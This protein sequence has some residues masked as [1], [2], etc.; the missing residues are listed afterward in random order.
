MQISLFILKIKQKGGIPFL[1]LFT[2]PASFNNICQN[3]G[4]LLKWDSVMR[5]K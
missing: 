5:Q 2:Y 4:S 3:S 1:P